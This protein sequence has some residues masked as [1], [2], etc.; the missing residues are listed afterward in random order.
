M[1]QKISQKKRTSKLKENKNI[2]NLVGDFFMYIFIYLL[3][4]ADTVKIFRFIQSS[5]D[6]KK[7]NKSDLVIK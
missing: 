3:L 6:G 2:M 1:R 5:V 7:A 4:P